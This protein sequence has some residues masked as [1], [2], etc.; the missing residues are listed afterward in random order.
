MGAQAVI[1]RALLSSDVINNS[2]FS[3]VIRLNEKSSLEALGSG[4]DVTA[5]KLLPALIRNVRRWRD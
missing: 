2:R 1:A 4:L 3:S 5:V